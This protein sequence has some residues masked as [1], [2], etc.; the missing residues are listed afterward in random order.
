M[1]AQLDNYVRKSNRKL[2]RRNK[3]KFL[4][5]GIPDLIFERAQDYGM[6]DFKVCDVH[7]VP[8]L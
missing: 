5:H 2:P 1:Q 3:K 7:A 4:P 6:E 8:I